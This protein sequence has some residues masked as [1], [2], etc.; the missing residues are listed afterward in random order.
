MGGVNFCLGLTREGEEYV[1]LS[2]LLEDIIKL[3][4]TPSQ[5]LAIIYHIIPK[6]Y[7]QINFIMGLTVLQKA[8]S[9]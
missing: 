5:V 3:T 1:P 6:R 7:K 2:V 9:I 8:V 4:D